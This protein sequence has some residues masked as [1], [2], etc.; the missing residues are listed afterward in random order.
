MWREVVPALDHLEAVTDGGSST[1]LILDLLKVI[2]ELVPHAGNIEDISTKVTAIY[3][4]LQV[5]EHC[6]IIIIIW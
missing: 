5:G 6:Y 4:K 3:D 2:A 1:T